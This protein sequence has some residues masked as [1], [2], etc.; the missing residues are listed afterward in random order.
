MSK[1]TWTEKELRSAIIS[2]RSIAQALIKL[3]LKPKGGN[4]Q[5]FNK[6]VRIFSLDVTHFLGRG[7]KKGLSVP[8]KSKLPLE[9]ILTKESDYQSFKLKK[10]LFSAKLKP[11]HCELCGWSKRTNN[12]YLPLELDHINGDHRDNRLENL[13]VLCPNCHSLQPGHRGRTK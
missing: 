11:E 9:V 2:S 1:R 6:Y 5:Q 13:R 4:Y 3:G 8:Q 12:G 7:W 10:R